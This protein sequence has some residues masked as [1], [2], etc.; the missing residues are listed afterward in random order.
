MERVYTGCCAQGR[1][2]TGDHLRL[3]IGQ[4]SV[5]E[6]PAP[7]SREGSSP[8]LHECRMLGVEPRCG[9]ALLPCLAAHGGFHTATPNWPRWKQGLEELDPSSEPGGPPPVCCGFH[10]VYLHQQLLPLARMQGAAPAACSS[11]ACAFWGGARL[12]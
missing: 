5:E 10:M 1:A 7:A 11:A 9:S 2:R 3:T 6:F 4:S 12:S 8:A